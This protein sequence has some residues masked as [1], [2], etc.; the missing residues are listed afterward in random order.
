M[1]THDNISGLVPFISIL[2]LNINIHCQICELQKT[3]TVS[4][5]RFTV[6]NQQE[7]RLSQISVAITAG[8]LKKHTKNK[9]KTFTFAK[10]NKIIPPILGFE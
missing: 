6:Q 4:N 3:T 10:E 5:I 1:L 2:V 8:L 9:K 7:M